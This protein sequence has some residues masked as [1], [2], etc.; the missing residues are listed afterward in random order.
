LDAVLGLSVTPTTLGWVLA[1]GHAADGTVLGH[2]EVLLRTGH[3]VRAVR[4]AQQIAAEVLR[5]DALPSAGNHRLRVIGVAWTDEASAQAALLMEALAGA[6]FD[7][8]VPVR[9]LD[10]VNCLAR[11]IAPVIGYQR[12][13]VCILDDEW[14]TIVTVDTQDGQARTAERVHGGF[15]ELTRRLTGMFEG[16]GWR[17]GGVVVVGADADIDGLSWQLEKALPVPVFAQTMAH[18][19]VA[20][21]AA[22]AAA[23]RTDFTDEQMLAAHTGEPGLARRRQWSYAGAATALAAGAVTFVSALSLAVVMQLAPHS[24]TTAPK[25]VVQAQK[26]H[27]AAAVAPVPGPPAAAP[28][29]PASPQPVPGP[30]DGRVPGHTPEG[31]AINH[32]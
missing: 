18:V 12:V 31:A 6:G 10:A 2:R 19:T 8:V 5:V 22:L 11:A 28:Q 7:N 25:H 26:P 29:P 21:G 13:A 27:V 20:R 14:V 16:D 17:P 24:G 15:D 23:K 3:G 1:E 9:L 30:V 4:S 32:P